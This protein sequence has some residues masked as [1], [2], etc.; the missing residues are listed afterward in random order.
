MFSLFRN[1]EGHSL[2]Y[3]FRR[4]DMAYRN[5]FAFIFASG[6]IPMSYGR[7]YRART[8]RIDPDIVGS[9]VNGSGQG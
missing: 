6:V 2:R 3:I 8:Y 1:Q 9:E 7:S 4:T 5:P